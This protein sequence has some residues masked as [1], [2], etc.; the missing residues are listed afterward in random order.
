MASSQ[1]S[2]DGAWG[3]PDSFH[4]VKQAVGAVVRRMVGAG[5]P[6]YEDLVQSSLLTVVATLSAGRFRGECPDDGGRR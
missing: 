1:N 6:E 3:G 2:R 4:T 5:D